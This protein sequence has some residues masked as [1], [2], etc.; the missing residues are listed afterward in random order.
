MCIALGGETCRLHGFH[1]YQPVSLID[2]PLYRVGIE[3]ETAGSSEWLSELWHHQS[4]MEVGG[5]GRFSLQG[6]IQYRITWSQALQASSNPALFWWISL[7]FFPL[8]VLHVTL[9]WAVPHQRQHT[10]T[11]TH[12]LTCHGE[13]TQTSTHKMSSQCPFNTKHS[14]KL[15]NV[16][17][18]NSC[19][20]VT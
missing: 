15:V 3:Q 12:R 18:F 19:W 9:I 7:C 10:N 1:M 11:H 6:S 13:A 5:A 17:F 20:I 8:L 14:L 16:K 4:E 2:L